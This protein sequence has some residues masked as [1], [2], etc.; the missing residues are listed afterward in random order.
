[1]DHPCSI[2]TSIA[3]HSFF[4]HLF[5]NW[6]GY[7]DTSC[8]IKVFF[9]NSDIVCILVLEAL[10][11]TELTRSEKGEDRVSVC[12]KTGDVAAEKPGT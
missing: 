8:D 6:I 2:S 5:W 10:E 1:M 7:R 11:T 4:V 9:N 12:R 3:S